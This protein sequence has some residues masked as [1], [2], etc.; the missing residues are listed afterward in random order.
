MKSKPFSSPLWEQLDL[1]RSKRRGRETWKEIA[2]HLNT[3]EGLNTR[4]LNIHYKTLQNFFKR[5]SEREKMP[6]G[7]EDPPP[8][9]A[10]PAQP[11]EETKNTKEEPEASTKPGD[12]Y[13]K[14]VL[15]DQQKPAKL[16]DEKHLN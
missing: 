1:I 15:E 7:W 14:T 16:F 13:R 4:G 9:A 10:A 6:L 11:I 3:A 2:T 12:K 8:S 5:V